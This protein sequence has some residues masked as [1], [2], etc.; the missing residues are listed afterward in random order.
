MEMQ[1]KLESRARKRPI[2]RAHV[3]HRFP[4]TCSSSY[5]CPVCCQ[6]RTD[7]LFLFQRSPTPRSVYA[8][9]HAYEAGELGT[10]LSTGELSDPQHAASSSRAGP[11][12]SGECQLEGEV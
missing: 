8:T 7:D 2:L 6:G 5:V 11:I 10:I 12:Q 4:T 1:C 3:R 9:G